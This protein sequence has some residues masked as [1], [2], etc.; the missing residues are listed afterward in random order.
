MSENR[1]K[2]SKTR[3]YSSD[4]LHRQHF[5]NVGMK[6]Q[7]FRLRVRLN[8]TKRREPTSIG[9]STTGLDLTYEGGCWGGWW[10]SLTEMRRGPSR[11][12][13]E[14]NVASLKLNKFASR[15]MHC[16]HCVYDIHLFFRRSA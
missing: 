3:F 16:Q 2:T 4:A 7:P 8:S 13:L 15:I 1:Q 10:E 11:P 14:H 5:L 6:L 9:P 12:P